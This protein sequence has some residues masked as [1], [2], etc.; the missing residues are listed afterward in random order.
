[1]W[2]ESSVAK[3]KKG[4]KFPLL[5]YRRWAKM[6]RLPSLLISVVSAVGWYFAPEDTQSLLAGKAWLLLGFSGVGALI[7]LYSLRAHHAAYVQCFPAYIK[8]Q[9]PLFAVAVS[10]KRIRQ[11]RPVEYHAE[12]PLS[13]MKQSRRRLI[14]PFLGRTVVLLDLA[15]F[16]MTERKL[17]L[18]LP[19]Y[20]FA[21]KAT[22][23]LLVVEDWMALSRQIGVFT[24]RWVARRQSRHRSSFGRTY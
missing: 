2:G 5:I 7:F 1:M 23:F 16:P 6:L 4:T 10:Y 24:D 15:K 17:R 13:N 11:V 8:I 20:M 19:W 9:T 12:L 22:G 3:E 14:E 18:W 21:Q